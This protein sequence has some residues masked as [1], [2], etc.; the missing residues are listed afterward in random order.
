MLS[1]FSRLQRSFARVLAAF[2]LAMLLAFGTAARAAGTDS[3]LPAPMEQSGTGG[4]ALIRPGA[5]QHAG[6]PHGAAAE[7][8]GEEAQP[9]DPH[10]GTL[11]N[12]I[13]RAITGEAAPKVEEHEG[14]HH[15]VNPKSIRYDYIVLS[16]IVMAL[17]GL[18]TALAARKAKVRPEGKAASLANLTEASVEGYREYVIGIM[19][20]H[21]GNKYGSLILSFFFTILFFNWLGLIPGLM[22]PTANPNV[23]ISL[24]LVAF[25]CTHFIAIREVGIVNWMKHFADGPWFLLWLL[26]PL[27]IL[28]EFI[29][30]LSLALR[31]LCNVFGEE[32]VIVQLAGLAVLAMAA[33]KIPIPFQLP[34]LFLSLFF[35]F[36]QALVFSTLLAIYIS[37]MSTHHDEEGHG[38]TDHHT[39]GGH[40]ELVTV[41]GTAPMA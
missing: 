41:N 1:S 6:T 10:A 29:K 3:S 36:L 33:T 28:G 9:F 2:A 18:V 16:F 23:P 20:T 27:H 15:V 40:D 22:S 31:L 34:M 17:L 19:G 32:L 7:A 24:A 30:P 12:P 26:I 5:A 35:G 25:F 21:L 14:A 4:T 13:A 37:T 8:H 38:H 39:V 11:V